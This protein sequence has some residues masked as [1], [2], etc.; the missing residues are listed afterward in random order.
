MEQDNN[1][2]DAEKGQVRAQPIGFPALASLVHRQA[3]LMT[4]LNAPSLCL[5]HETHTNFTVLDS[6]FRPVLTLP[7]HLYDQDVQTMPGGVD[8]V[9]EIIELDDLAA[10]VMQ[11]VQREPGLVENEKLTDSSRTANDEKAPLVTAEAGGRGK[12]PD[13]SSD[14]TKESHPDADVSL[15]VTIYHVIQAKMGHHLS[16][17]LSGEAQKPDLRKRTRSY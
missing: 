16:W 2:S 14:T 3:G 9:T 7:K 6:L 17:L 8:S 12:G 1:L 11:N 15:A 4:A 13:A 10:D 5:D